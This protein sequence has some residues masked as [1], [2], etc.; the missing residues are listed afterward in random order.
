MSL[1]AS[2][3]LKLGNVGS[4]PNAKAATFTAGTLTLQPASSA[5]PGLVTTGTQTFAGDKQFTGLIKGSFATPQKIDLSYGAN[6]IG[7]YTGSVSGGDIAFLDS[8]GTLWGVWQTDGFHLRTTRAIFYPYTDSSGTPGAA[9]I[10][11]GSGRSAI[12]SLAAAVTI[13]NSVVTATS[14]VL[15]APEDLDATL[16]T[17]KVVPAAGSFVVTGNA[18]ATLDWKFRWAVFKGE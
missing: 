17:Y 16:L 18:A 10:N 8:G 11:K 15:I 14:I 6:G 5:Q 2:S 3:S 12:A 7:L 1:K 4:S 13:T 9:T